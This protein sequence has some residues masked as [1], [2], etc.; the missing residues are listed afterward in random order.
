MRRL[1]SMAGKDL[2]RR[3]RSPLAVAIMLA[4]PLLFSLVM[5]VTSFSAV[6]SLKA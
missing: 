2:L 4:F 3:W 6:R 1:L 5:A